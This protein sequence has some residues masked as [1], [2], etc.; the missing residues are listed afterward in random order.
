M[1]GMITLSFVLALFVA[2]QVKHF[3]VDY[4]LQS[5]PYFLG[6]FRKGWDFF[7]PLALH[8]GSHGLATLSIVLVAMTYMVRH[9]MRPPVMNVYLP[10][11]VTVFDAVVHFLMDRVK[12]SPRWMGRWKPLTAEQ[13][14]NARADLDF[15]DGP[16]TASH[17]VPA[18]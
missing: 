12:A 1:T 7:W 15:A 3:L 18:F 17:C 13:Y 9:G 14:L 8:A 16:E 6:K 4:P 2:F 5:H 10:F 11:A